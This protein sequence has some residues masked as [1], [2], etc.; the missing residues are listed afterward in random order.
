[1]FLDGLLF[2]FAGLVSYGAGGLAGRLTGSL[3]LAAAAG[4]HRCLEV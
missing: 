2:S 4:F 1:M 3:T